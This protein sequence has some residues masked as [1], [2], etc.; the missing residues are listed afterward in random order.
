MEEQIKDCAERICIDA[1]TIYD[2]D[3]RYKNA[4]LD[5]SGFPSPLRNEGD[6]GKVVETIGMQKWIFG[7]E[8]GYYVLEL[9]LQVEELSGTKKVDLRSDKLSRFLEEVIGDP[10]EPALIYA[11]V[12]RCLV[13]I[14]T[15]MEREFQTYLDTLPRN[16]RRDAEAIL[17]YDPQDQGNQPAIKAHQLEI[18]FLKE[19][20]K[21]RQLQNKLMALQQVIEEEARELLNS[22]TFLGVKSQK[23][24]GTRERLMMAISKQELGEDSIYA[25]RT[26][27][28]DLMPKKPRLRQRGL[29]DRREAEVILYP[30]G[31]PPE[32]DLFE[33]FEK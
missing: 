18:C 29:T 30:A 13:S 17:K 11:F 2:L 23:L 31:D 20:E 24:Q 8:R 10:T 6:L 3:K 15:S 9:Y 16:A 5:T 27:P 7:A 14:K 28:S 33:Q 19:R 22:R 21:K 1:H 25:E 12:H 4:H 32:E 26:P